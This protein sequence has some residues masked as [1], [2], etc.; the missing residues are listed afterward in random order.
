MVPTL[1]RVQNKRGDHPS[2]D[3][4]EG[5]E[6]FVYREFIK[7]NQSIPGGLEADPN[8][9]N[10]LVI[11]PNHQSHGSR[12]SLVSWLLSKLQVDHGGLGFWRPIG[13]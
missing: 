4:G 5:Q 8:N 1:D 2:K 6:Q 7:I 10:T 9:G 13:S 3:R 12:T 11:L